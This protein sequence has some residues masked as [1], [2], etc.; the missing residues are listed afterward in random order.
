MLQM[1]LQSVAHEHSVYTEAIKRRMDH[2][3]VNEMGQMVGSSE[4]FLDVSDR[5]PRK[6]CIFTIQKEK[7]QD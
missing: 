1:Q 7:L 5:S 3:H 2:A 4:G 6:L